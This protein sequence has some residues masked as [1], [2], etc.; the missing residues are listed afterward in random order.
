MLSTFSYTVFS[1]SDI[2]PDYWKQYS[3]K[4]AGYKID[5]PS[6]WKAK[7]DI[8][9]RVWHTFF[10]SPGIRDYDALMTS[11]IVICSQPK[12]HISTSSNSRSRCSQ[13]DD[14]LSDNAKDKVISEETI[15]IN[16]IQIRKK[17]TK[18]RLRNATYIY[19]FF[20]T[21]DREILMS[22]V[23]NERLNLDKYI[24]VFDQMLAT[25]QLL[26]KDTIL[27]YKNEKYGFSIAYPTTWRSCPL[28]NYRTKRE[29]VLRIVSEETRCLGG[30][31]IS[32]LDLPES[33]KVKSTL[34]LEQLLENEKYSE[35]IPNFEFGNIRAIYGEKTEG[36]HI[37]RQRYFYTNQSKPYNLLKITEMNNKEKIVFQNQAKEILET[38]KI[39]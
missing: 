6:N 33:L 14:H 22:S 7:E 11:T 17:I 23:F 3:S 35:I 37:Y 8:Q 30:N 26:E 38:A 16:G 9:G 13:S 19:A 12:G 20:S 10:I 39:F 1:Q 36:K 2:T 28:D 32:I 24:P 4:T 5:Y 21:K 34:D 15:E 18:P 27:T 31:Y 29:E 25:L